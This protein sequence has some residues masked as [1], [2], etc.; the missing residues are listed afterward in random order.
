MHSGDTVHT[1]TTAN[2]T[3]LTDNSLSI[4]GISSHDLTKKEIPVECHS[5]HD[6]K[7]K[8][9]FIPNRAARKIKST[10]F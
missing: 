5:E 1:F 2:K 8:I 9:K 7:K 4:L 6:P 3:A 10:F